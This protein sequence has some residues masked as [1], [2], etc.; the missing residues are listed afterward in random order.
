MTLQEKIQTR[1]SNL[2]DRDKNGHH[3]IMSSLRYEE[4]SFL[5]EILS[6]IDELERQVKQYKEDAERYRWLRSCARKTEEFDVVRTNSE[7]DLDY[8]IDGFKK[9]TK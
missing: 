9:K 3:G 8:A 6:R 1:I 2:E 4:I 5:E 7:E